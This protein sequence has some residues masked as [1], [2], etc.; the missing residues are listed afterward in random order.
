MPDPSDWVN[1]DNAVGHASSDSDDIVKT[2]LTAGLKL[3]G[4]DKG[5]WSKIKHTLQKQVSGHHYTDLKIQPM[6]YS[7]QNGLDACQHTAIKYITR[8]REKGGQVDLD[9]AIH[10]IEMLKEFEYGKEE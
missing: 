3:G 9:K 10:C 2:A 6:D 7:M 5:H 1:Y 4:D 8:F